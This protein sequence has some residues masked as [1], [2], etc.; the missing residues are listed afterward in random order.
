MRIA[1][2]GTGNVG[3]A[4]AKKWS[5]A[6]HDIHL[7]VRDIASFDQPEISKLPNVQVQTVQEAV[8]DSDV[9]LLATPAPAAADVA[10]S[11]G[12]TNGK[13]IIDAMNIV[14]GNGPEGFNNTSDAILAHTR[15]RDVVKCFNTTGF[16]NMLEPVYGDTALDMWMAGDSVI[17]KDIAR[18]LAL[19]AGFANCYDAGGNDAFYLMEQFANFWIHLAIF[20]KEGRQI[21]F[22][23]L[24]RQ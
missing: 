12:D 13:V 20:R 21:G 24:R 5:A 18:Q 22:K 3:S 4:L 1:I 11:L 9:I 10:G 19:D 17:G 6:G 14:K 2:I 7:G 8:K 16:D 15:T 23:L